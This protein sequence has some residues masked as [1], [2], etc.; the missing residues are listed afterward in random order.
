MKRRV[1]DD[2]PKEESREVRRMSTLEK[3]SPAP[4]VNTVLV[5]DGGV[6]ATFFFA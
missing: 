3:H 6:V 2:E 4:E 1:R 5:H